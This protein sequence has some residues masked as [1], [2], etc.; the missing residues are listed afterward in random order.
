M[1]AEGKRLNEEEWGNKSRQL[2]EKLFLPSCRR[3][4]RLSRR[5]EIMLL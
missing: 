2:A 3:F 4:D 1:K 5:P